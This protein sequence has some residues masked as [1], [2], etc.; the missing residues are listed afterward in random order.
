[1]A[2]AYP[3]SICSRAEY[4][5]RTSNHSAARQLGK[6]N[7]PRLF[8]T[9]FNWDHQISSLSDNSNKFL[10]KNLAWVNPPGPLGSPIFLLSAIKALDFRFYHRITHIFAIKVLDFLWFYHIYHIYHPLSK[11]TSGVLSPSPPMPLIPVLPL[12]K[13]AAKTAS[14]AT[15]DTA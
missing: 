11:R 4:R 8:S 10:K 6:A 9:F 13:H 3:P 5:H 7:G 12:P 2:H 1:M 15:A 14:T